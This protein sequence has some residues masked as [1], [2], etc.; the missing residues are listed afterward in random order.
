M[1]WSVTFPPEASTKNTEES[2]DT[3]ALSKALYFGS[4]SM[5]PFERILYDTLTN[6]EIRPDLIV[7]AVIRYLEWD[8]EN[9]FYRQLFSLYLIDR[10]LYWLRFHS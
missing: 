3:Y 4:N 7:D 5:D 9:A 6:K 2:S 1:I 8:D 10:A